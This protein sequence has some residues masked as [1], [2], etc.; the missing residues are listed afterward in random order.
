MEPVIQEKHEGYFYAYRLL[1][2]NLDNPTSSWKFSNYRKNVGSIRPLAHPLAPYTN[3][4]FRVMASSFQSEGLV[5]EAFQ[6][7]TYQ[8]GMYFKIQLVVYYQCC[9]LISRAITRLYVIAH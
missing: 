8:W 9:V 4:S 2:K 1:Y 3:Y 5:S 7:R 6:A